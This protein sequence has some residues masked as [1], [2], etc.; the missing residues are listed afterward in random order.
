MN[1]K[2]NLFFA[3][4]ALV[5]LAGCTSDDFVG[6][7]SLQEANNS[8][9][10]I[11]FT[12][13]TPAVTR[14][15]R[16]GADAAGDLNRNFVVFGYKTVS[17]S[18]QTVF[19]NYQVNWVTNTAGSTESNTADWEYVSYKNL[20]YGTTTTSGGTLNNN[21]VSANATG[22]STN[23]IQSIK[24]WDFSASS[25]DFF[26]YSLGAGV[27]ESSTTTWAKASALSNST[28]TLEGTAA[29]LGTCY[30]SKKKHIDPPSSA[31]VNLVFL[32]FLSK[33]QLKFFETIPG[34]SVKDVR[35][36]IDADNKSTG[37]ETK[38]GLAPALYTTSPSSIPTGGKY[39]ITFDE[40]YDPVVTLTGSAS[41]TAT[42]ISFPEAETGTPAKWLSGLVGKEYQEEDETVYLGRTA[43]AASASK[44]ITV[45][46]NSTGAA[47]TL[48][49]DYTLVSRDG[50]SEA[51]TVTGATATVPADFTKWKPNYAYTYIFK[52]SD[53]TNGSTGG[54]TTGLYPITLD[55]IVTETLD[56][57]Q[58]TITTV[59]ATSITTYQ[60]GA[61]AN[62]YVEGNIY[63]VVGD[64]TTALTSTNAKL[65]TATIEA[66][67]AQGLD[68]EGKPAI[69]EEMVANALTKSLTDGKYTLTDANNKKLTVTPVTSGSDALEVGQTSIPSTDAPGG[70]ELAVKCAKFNASDN[71]IYVFEYI[72]G[73]SNKY[74][75]VIKVGTPTAVSGS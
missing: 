53:N 7:Q 56:G 64:G 22:S 68:S 11:N 71:T 40:N 12:M 50:S 35:F 27:T 72:D 75:K 37:T 46:P 43:N 32:S 38:D 31:E 61:V 44:Q 14:A 54:S 30:I 34:Y 62:E 23:I 4:I 60:N 21:G 45:L 19:D 17:S 65:Y 15:D 69:T 24:Y 48:K 8:G 51:I 58:T 2:K 18:D 9:G 42:S 63:V 66:G 26:A 41:S 29:Q 16:T 49:V 28:Y 5:A 47:I 70:K 10:A 67:A 33:I 13:K 52:I 20:P 36:Y 59:S 73:S 25:Y 1:M 3:A 39:T 6:N 57:S 74:Y 55:A